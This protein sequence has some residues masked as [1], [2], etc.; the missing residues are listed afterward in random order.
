MKTLD[1]LKKAKIQLVLDHPFFAS[2]ALQMRY[3]ED[4]NIQTAITNG[5]TVR[6]NPAFIDELPV[7]QVAGVVAHEMLHVISLHHTRI[8]KR[9]ISLWNK[10]ADF[11]INPLL[12]KANLELPE[13][14]LLN[15]RFDNMNAERIY[16]ILEQEHEPEEPQSE[17]AP[18]EEGIGDFDDLP[19]TENRQ[20]AEAQIK[21]YM[22]EAAMIARRQG[23]LPDFIERMISEILHPKISWKEALQSFFSEVVNDDFTWEKPSVRYLHLGLYLPSLKNPQLGSVILILDTSGSIDGDL[24]NAFAAEVQE[25]TSAFNIPLSI[26]YVD[27]E[28]QTVQEIEPDETISLRPMGGGGTDFTPGFDYIEM[29]GLEPTV[30]IYMTDG[31]CY[32]YPA[33][34]SYDVLWAKFG[35]FPFNPP[36]GDVIEVFD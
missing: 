25:I 6:Y 33:T 14:R 18:K 15:E 4:N 35:A 17:P 26:L 30:V 32:S 28:V 24:I 31:A 12:I 20:Q 9:N 1:K 29:H 34:P 5:T 23:K 19:A 8:G 22:A 21:Q 27:E 16:A 11:A 7:K 3:E 36:F 13:C 10:A 2:I